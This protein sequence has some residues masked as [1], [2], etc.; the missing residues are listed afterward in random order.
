MTAGTP[1]VTIFVIRSSK[2][3]SC[4]CGGQLVAS[5]CCY[6]YSKRQ[7]MSAHC[8]QLLIQ[9]CFG[10]MLCFPLSQCSLAVIV[11]QAT[12]ALWTNVIVAKHMK[13]NELQFLSHWWNCSSQ[14]EEPLCSQ[15]WSLHFCSTHLSLKV[16]LLF[17]L[18]VWP[19]AFPATTCPTSPAQV[20]LHWLLMCVHQSM[21][22]SHRC[23]AEEACL[24]CTAA[25]QAAIKR[26]WH[27][28]LCSLL[29]SQCVHNLEGLREP[30]LV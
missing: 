30:C 23:R 24:L 29:V 12:N 21:N 11:I 1:L 6:T 19:L 22:A 7:L 26:A 17:W 8:E 15:L 2:N 14:S 28:G 20:W 27:A 9:L 5:L 18:N 16:M 3:S 4:S 10:N 13:C 25:V